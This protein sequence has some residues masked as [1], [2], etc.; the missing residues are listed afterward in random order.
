GLFHSRSE[1]CPTPARSETQTRSEEGCASSPPR[2]C[3]LLAEQRLF[4]MPIPFKKPD[5]LIGRFAVV[6][7][8]PET[9]AAEDE[10]IARLQITARSLG[11]ECVVVDPEGIRLDPPHSRISDRDVDFVIH[12][13]FETPKAYNAFSFVVLWN[14]LRFF[15]DWGYRR[16]SRHLLSHDDF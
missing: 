5:G 9:Q 10:N 4:A 6:K 1:T 12:L 7:P 16:Y 2:R 15:K 3:R 14:P 11:L 13:H 8:W